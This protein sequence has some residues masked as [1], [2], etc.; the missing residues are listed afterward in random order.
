MISNIIS[1]P[2]S[3]SAI[4]E[5]PSCRV[6]QLWPKVEDWEQE[7]ILCKHYMF[8]FNHCDAIGVQSY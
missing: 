4:A 8:I 2:T 5:R 6:N 3:S 7:T 1:L